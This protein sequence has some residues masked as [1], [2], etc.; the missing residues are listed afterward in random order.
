[1]NYQKKEV[2][3]IKYLYYILK[4]S[5]SRKVFV[6]FECLFSFYYMYAWVSMCSDVHMGIQVPMG[7]RRGHELAYSWS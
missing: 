1:M 7:H 4:Y 3:P 2:N 5:K 6:Y